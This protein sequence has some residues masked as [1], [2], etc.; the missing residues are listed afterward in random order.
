MDAGQTDTN[1]VPP[2]QEDQECAGQYN[3]VDDVGDVRVV[4]F[5]SF[6]DWPQHKACWCFNLFTLSR[7]HYLISKYNNH[8]F[9]VCISRW[10]KLS[11]LLRFP[12]SCRV[13]TLWARRA[14]AYIC[15]TKQM[16]KNSPMHR[17]SD[18]W[19]S[20]R[21]VH[22][23]FTHAEAGWIFRIAFFKY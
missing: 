13:K 21:F 16:R 9:P 14:K 7:S 22:S 20:S 23:D 6:E 2:N 11:R 10:A 19:S 8:L 4:L 17:K 3:A 5:T 15:K 18:K 1:N 12:P